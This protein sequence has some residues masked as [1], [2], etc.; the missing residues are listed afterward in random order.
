MVTRIQMHSRHW[1]YLQIKLIS[2]MP[3][4]ATQEAGIASRCEPMPN[5][6]GQS[7]T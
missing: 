3:D 2:S 7:A 1:E 6:L 5:L 4:H